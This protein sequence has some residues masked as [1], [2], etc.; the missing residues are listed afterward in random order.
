MAYSFRLNPQAGCVAFRMHGTYSIADCREATNL[1]MADSA[2]SNSFMQ[3]TDL[4]GITDFAADFSQVSNLVS[5]LV[6]ASAPIVPGTLFV[7]IATGDVHYGMARMFQQLIDGRT[8]FA[9]H[10]VRSRAEAARIMGLT[11]DTLDRLLDIP[12]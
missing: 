1:A 9:L 6:S 11:A 3:V 2:F 12:D 8:P 7:L 10:L 5:F 4:S